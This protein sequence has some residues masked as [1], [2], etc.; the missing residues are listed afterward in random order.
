M[1]KLDLEALKV[2]SFP[3]GRF[4]HWGRCGNPACTAYDLLDEWDA[5]SDCEY[6]PGSDDYGEGFYPAEDVIEVEGEA[7]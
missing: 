3:T 7:V 4:A 1:S 6:L 5:C 2:E